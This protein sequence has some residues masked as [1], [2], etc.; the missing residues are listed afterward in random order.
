[1][2]CSRFADSANWAC[3]APTGPN[4]IAQGNALGSMDKNKPSPERAQSRSIP[5]IAFVIFD[6]VFFEQTPVFLL[7]G[8]D[9]MVLRLIG[10]IFSQRRPM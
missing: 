8:H 6:A 3:L 4:A 2:A 7:K 10:D 1:M 9:P 5:H